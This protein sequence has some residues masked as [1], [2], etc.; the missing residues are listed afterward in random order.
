MTTSV[1]L[2]TDVAAFMCTHAPG[3]PAPPRPVAPVQPTTTLYLGADKVAHRGLAGLGAD[4][5]RAYQTYLA[6]PSMVSHVVPELTGDLA[7]RIHAGL[8]KRLQAAPIEDVR[9]DFEDGYGVR[10]D[11]TEDADLAACVANLK[12]HAHANGVMP[13]R[14]GVRPKA[15]THDDA[16]R[17]LRTVRGFVQ[18]VAEQ[19]RQGPPFQPVITL[20]K[21]THAEQVTL[22][23]RYLAAH[24]TCVGMRPGTLRLEHMNETREAMLAPDGRFSLAQWLDAASPRCQAVHLGVYDYSANLDVAPW[25]QSP[26]HSVCVHARAWLKLLC[27]P[28]GLEVSDGSS[29]VLPLERHEIA[30]NARERHAN[31]SSVW[32]AWRL[33]VAHVQAALREGVVQGWALHPAQIPARWLAHA[34][35]FLPHLQSVC[36]RLADLLQ[37][38]TGG[39][40]FD[41]AAT[42]QALFRAIQRM[43]AHGW[44]AP[45]DI[46]QAGLTLAELNQPTLTAVLRTRR[47]V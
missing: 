17:C 11:A 41:D 43:H 14:M 9:W 20:P 15:L 12:T 35:F 22:M 8:G 5:M 37:A 46:E 32:A 36:T 10:G 18:G 6:A 45:R 16:E 29:A 27:E 40:I 23:C 7:V 1:A 42:G 44:L 33:E 13:V 26:R 2:H 28:R 3:R 4:V 34:A 31:A 19:W 30:H 39:Q 21:V 47:G 38:R 25:L 24:E